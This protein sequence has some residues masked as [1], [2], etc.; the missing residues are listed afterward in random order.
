MWYQ[1]DMRLLLCLGVVSCLAVFAQKKTVFVI[2]DAEGVGGV[3]GRT[4]P[5]PK[6]RRCANYSPAKSMPP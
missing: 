4:R 5:I 3:A 2:T 6:I 1:I